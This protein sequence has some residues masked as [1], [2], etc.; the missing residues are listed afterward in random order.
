MALG[1][2]NKLFTK[3]KALEGLKYA[4]P[5]FTFSMHDLAEYY[6]V[7]LEEE[8]KSKIG[9]QSLLSTDESKT[10][11]AR[12]THSVYN[13]SVHRPKNRSTNNISL[14]DTHNHKRK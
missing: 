9:S 13:D 2:S 7:Q 4:P 3:L 11:Q 14:D 12:N 8:S 6:G 5:K 1:F 10:V